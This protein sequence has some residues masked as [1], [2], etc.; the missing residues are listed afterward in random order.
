MISAF[1]KLKSIIN[2]KVSMKN[3]TDNNVD[4]NNYV[5]TGIYY[6]GANITNA[7]TQYIKMIV[8]GADATKNGDTAQIAISI[9]S[10]AIYVR[11]GNFSTNEQK[12]NWHNWIC[13]YQNITT[14]TEFETG[15][16]IDGKKEYG[17]R[18]NVG[19]LTKETLKTVNSGINSND[20]A[21]TR[22]SGCAISSYNGRQ[23]PIPNSNIEVGIS[24]TLLR[25]TSKATYNHETS[26]YVEIYYTKN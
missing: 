7:P 3:V 23:D 21:L 5:E 20:Y 15:R 19:P 25:V 9:S 8:L 2:S 18:I 16:T 13:L 24:G 22:I 10:G 1:S 11:T 4:C 26:C 14:G 17:R 6:L 12:I